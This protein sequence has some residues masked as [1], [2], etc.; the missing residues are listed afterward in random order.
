MFTPYWYGL[1]FGYLVRFSYALVEMQILQFG[2]LHI[3]GYA[4]ESVL[5][6]NV[7]GHRYFHMGL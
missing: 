2:D 1:F 7:H 3:C 4:T 6:I 5:Q